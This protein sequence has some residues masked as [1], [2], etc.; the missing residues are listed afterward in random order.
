V[1]RIAAWAVGGIAIVVIVAALYLLTYRPDSSSYPLRGVDVSR[2]QGKV[3]WQKVAGDDIAFAYIKA[4]EGGTWRD[5]EFARNWRDAQN[6]GLATGAYHFFT[7]CR[8]GRDQ[9]RNFL[10][11]LPRQDKML[12]PVVDLEFVGNCDRR[13]TPQELKVELDDFLGVVEGKLG[14]EVMLYVPA[15]FLAAY[16]EALPPRPLWRRSLFRPPRKNDWTLWQYHFAGQVDG[17][18]GGVDLNV[19]NGDE[20]EFAGLLSGSPPAE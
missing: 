5:P 12:P 2:H 19:F 9:A 14:R 10:A 13:L 17:V 3:D 6:A 20:V 15:D 1:L 11:V 18:D 4:T 8:P 7:M 16:R